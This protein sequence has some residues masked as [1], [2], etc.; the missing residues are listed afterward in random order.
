MPKMSPR[1]DNIQRTLGRIE[2]KLDGLAETFEDHIAD[3]QRNFDSVEKRLAIME[4]KI[5]TFTGALGI[6][7][8][9]IA[10]FKA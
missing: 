1:E 3:D 4:K 8:A 2:A 9:A 6:L 10:Y 7:W 5:Y